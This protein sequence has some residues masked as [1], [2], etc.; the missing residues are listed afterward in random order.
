MELRQFNIELNREIQE[1]KLLEQALWESREKLFFVTSEL[2]NSQE[3]ER[4]R[5]SR[6][7]HDELGQAFAGLKLHLSVIESGL[8]KDQHKLKQECV[9]LVAYVE[10]I[11]ENV[12][13]LA[14]DL[15]PVTLEVIG[16]SGSLEYFLS[17]CSEHSSIP[18]TLK[19]ANIDHLFSPN[20][21]I[22][23]YRILQE[24]M[25]NIIKYSKATHFSVL[26]D[27]RGKF[28]YFAV[29]DNGIGFNP[30]KLASRQGS[31]RCIGIAAMQERV[32][33][34]GGYIDI[35]SEESYGTR[36][37]FTLPIHTDILEPQEGA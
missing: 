26:I 31:H 35:W 21:K 24:C 11:M 13:R 18:C 32:R 16:L 5:I 1:R 27:I 14:W 12:H 37:I 9:R 25:T 30:V 28:V 8:R 15:S 2:L 10:K 7:L 3:D 19:I 20:G 33:M 23:I 34:L 29:E 17:D 36:V 6:E 4:R 22:N